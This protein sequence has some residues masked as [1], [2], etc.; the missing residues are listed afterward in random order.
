MSEAEITKYLDDVANGRIELTDALE[1]DILH[2]FR[3]AMMNLDLARARAAK[4]DEALEKERHTMAEA[5]GQVSTLGSLLAKTEAKR[6]AARSE[7]VRQI[8]SKG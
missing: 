3:E 8:H 6:R 7:G 1:A 2:R 4:L 5:S